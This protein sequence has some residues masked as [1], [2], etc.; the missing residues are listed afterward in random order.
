[1]PYYV[2]CCLIKFEHYDHL[3]TLFSC[4][5]I[6]VLNTCQ[7]V[8]VSERAAPETFPQDIFS[9]GLKPVGGPVH[10][11]VLDGKSNSLDDSTEEVQ[12]MDVRYVHL[13]CSEA[14]SLCQSFPITPSFFTFSFL[15][16]ISLQYTF[17]IVS[18][19]SSSSSVMNYLESRSC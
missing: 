9:N 3:K 2:F 10:P 8:N 14:Q 15:L 16:V 17:L 18:F 7:K 12:S 4:S 1:M 5:E 6:N 13:C 11:D 19:H